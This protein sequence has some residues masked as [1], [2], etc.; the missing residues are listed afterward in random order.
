MISFLITTKNEDHYIDNLITQVMGCMSD[1]DEIVL[2]DDYSDD[3]N[4]IKIIEKWRFHP[5]LNNRIFFYQHHLNNDFGSHKNYGLDKCSK[6]WVFQLDADELM[7]DFL[8]EH[9]HN[10]IESN[11]DN[12][13]LFLLPRVNTVDG[14][15]E[16]DVVDFRWR[17]NDRGWV[18]W[19]DYQ[20][21]LFRNNGKIKWINKVHEQLVGAE[22]P[23]TFPERD[24]TTGLPDATWAILHHKD[25]DRQRRQNEMYARIG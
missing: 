20:T 11:G 21:R 9:L 8:A 16:R 17:I 5:S 6:E 25:I 12:F 3:T 24:E 1:E 19:P 23:I 13:D 14:L 15:T 4:S 2:L 10:I 18:M 22:R 7:S